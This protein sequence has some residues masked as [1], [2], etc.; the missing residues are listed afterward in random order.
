MM[1]LFSGKTPAPANSNPP[2]HVV[3]LNLSARVHQVKAQIS[4][5]H[6]NT[7]NEQSI[8][9]RLYDVLLQD[10]RRLLE[11]LRRKHG[12]NMA[13]ANSAYHRD[14]ISVYRLM[15][16]DLNGMWALMSTRSVERKVKSHFA[17]SASAIDEDA[18]DSILDPISF[19]IFQDPVVTPE[20]ITYEKSVLL[21]Y[22]GK[23]RNR[24]PITKKSL[25]EENLAPN[26]A[27]K[28]IVSDFLSSRESSP[29]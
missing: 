3:A 20:G 12:Y 6:D 29:A 26:L 5:F 18:P 13:E 8:L 4:I 24:D 19:T 14:L 17:S 23:N 10:H 25:T 16:S 9:N 1:K 27:V 7:G 22:L 2:A 21:D 11:Q 28:A 15:L